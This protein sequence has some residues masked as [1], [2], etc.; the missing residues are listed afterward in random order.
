[1]KIIIDL[2]GLQRKGNRKRGIG[3]YCL[4]FTRGLIRYYPENE[5][6][7][8]TN[9]ALADISKYFADELNNSDLNVEYFC[10]P[11][12]GDINGP[13][14]GK[15]SKRWLSIQ[16]RSYALAIINADILL[17]TS[18]F[19]GFRDNS[20]VS[21]NRFFE[22]PPIVSIVYDLIPLIHSDQYLNNDSEY[23]HFYHQKINELS[24]L[25]GLF[26]IS[27]SSSREI[28]N[29]LDIDNEL[30]FNISSACNTKLFSSNISDST[31][32]KNY[33][34]NFLLYCGA[35]DPRKN[36]FR[37]I[38]AYSLLPPQL[39]LK[40]KLVLTGPYAEEEINR[41]KEWIL[42]F[43]L[44]LEYVIFLGYVND[45]ELRSLY[46][47]CYLFIFPSLHE[48]FGLPVLEAMNCGA[49]VIAS[50]LTSLPD[51]VGDQ[52]FLFDP[53]NSK[54]ISSLI[55]KSLTDHEF[56]QLLRSNSSER[57]KYF[58][59]EKTS[60]ITIE[61]LKKIIERKSKS[62]RRDKLEYKN[63]LHTQYGLLIKNLT[64][65]PLVHIKSLSKKD[66]SKSLASAI[67]IINEQS[68]R[69]EISRQLKH[70]QKLTWHIEGPFD[71]S[72]S[73]AILNRN[74]ALSMDRI[75]ENVS[76][77]CTDG[78][79]DYQPDFKFLEKNPS[80]N[81]LYQK[82]NNTRNSFYICSR[83]LYPPR[84][85]DVKGVINLLHAYGW[86]ESEFP[87]EWVH[88]FN[89][90]LQGVTVMSNFVK[91]ILIDNG[92]YIPIKVC[93]LGLDHI[94]DIQADNTYELNSRSYKI[95]H[96]SSCFPRKGID[97]L[98]KSYS[99]AFTCEDDVTLIIKT[100]ENPHNNIEE[101]L[102][103]LKQKNSNFPDVKI[104]ND[105]L[106][107]GELKSLYLH[108]D[109]LV[110]PSRGE[111]FGLPIAE[112]MLLGLPVITTAWGGQR[113]FCNESNCWLVDY[114]YSKSKTH[115]NLDFSYM[116]EPS[117]NQLTS[118]L[119]KVYSSNKSEILEKTDLAQKNVR[120]FLW[121]NVAQVNKLF[122][123][124]LITFA[125]HTRTKIGWVST[126]GSNCGIASYSNHLVDQ[127]EN[128]IVIFCPFNELNS[129]ESSNESVP[130]WNLASDTNKS[131]DNLFDQIIKRNISTLVIQFNYGFFDF[132]ELNHFIKKVKSKEI[133]IIVFLHSTIDPIKSSSK[134][135][136]NIRDSLA[137]CDRLM[138]HT[139][140]DMNRLKCLDLV[141]NVCI[142]PHGIL[143]FSPTKSNRFSSFGF[144]T[145]KKRRRI[146][147]YGFCLPNKGYSQLIEAVSLLNN[148]R[149]NIYLDIYSAIYN[150]EY[151]S[152]YEDLKNLIYKLNIQ[153][154]VTINPKYLSD[155][156]V[157]NCLSSY[158]FTIFPYQQSNESSS[159]AVRH[160]LSSLRP[161]LVTPLPVFDDVADLVHYLPGMTSSDIALGIKRWYENNETNSKNYN[162]ISQNQK[163][164]DKLN[165]M[166][167]SKIAIR[168]SSIIKSLEVNRY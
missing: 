22:L 11:T 45:I 91:K 148:R 40:H 44:P 33:L 14:I 155:V 123:S 9:S 151:L 16:I 75:G 154:R 140:S 5:Y 116:A 115:F 160:G 112:A 38:E 70:N 15:Y 128:E 122:V 81:R 30:I 98:L 57:V 114:E 103:Q 163:Y 49:P 111:G 72:Y 55:H 18:F 63:L 95:L 156:Q 131:L 61:S 12:V 80:I 74:F 149:F 139:I 58:S 65:S 159:A 32:D 83:N 168:L 153:N 20:L 17:I 53:Y 165:Q 124:N 161:V 76:L 3:R 31:I 121:K 68:R 126:W 1:M 120:S 109:V 43:G 117:I 127:M 137:L 64:E 24:L 93:G 157:L 6:I 141:D 41:I 25:D 142:F 50:N 42:N 136:V 102:N 36:L 73:L 108:S 118:Q 133:N 99:T 152:I 47:N 88:E 107:S 66:Y 145:F 67:E 158:D 129:I 105:E 82:G 119:I 100:F 54:D 4:E 130:S 2:Q 164:F 92:V 146:C 94:K 89:L 77:T 138:V 86:E 166:R 143:D 97:V 48:G 8:F 85:N 35:T 167:F 26:A 29:N 106:S 104:I 132:K 10:C 78:P 147:S 19:D 113:D 150:S 37:L 52:K 84:V 69:I 13:Y 28:S 79:G 87:Q 135:L 34:G 110:A 27:Q 23:Q 51:I 56:Y 7:L 134:S 101:Q 162:Y 21:H 39:I 125:N 62:F 96:I 46:K 60:K 59:W 71:T 144:N 90:N